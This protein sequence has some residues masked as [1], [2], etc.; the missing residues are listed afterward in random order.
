MYDPTSPDPGNPIIKTSLTSGGLHMI[1]A[2][3]IESG[4]TW[5]SLDVPNDGG[6]LRIAFVSDLAEQATTS[7]RWLK[8]VV[9]IEVQ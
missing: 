3:Q 7:S 8:W 2:D 4:G 5:A 1:L 9:K 6:P